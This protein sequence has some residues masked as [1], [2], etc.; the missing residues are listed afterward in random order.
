MRGFMNY[1]DITNLLNQEGLLVSC[2]NLSLSFSYLSY[3]IKDINENTLF[4]ITDEKDIQ[5]IK[6]YEDKITCYISEKEYDIKIPSIIVN[7]IISTTSIISNKFYNLEKEN[8]KLIGVI[9]ESGKTTTLELL[10]NNINYYY[11]KDYEI[12]NNSKKEIEIIELD[13]CIK[14]NKLK[15]KDILLV[16]LN[17][18][19]IDQ[20]KYKKFDTI[21][22]LNIKE[23]K[24]EKDIDKIISI[25]NNS[26]TIIMNKD[27]YYYEKINKELKENKVITYG[28]T[29]SN[30]IIKNIRNSFDKIVFTILYNNTITDYKINNKGEFNIIDSTASIICSLILGVKYISIKKSLENTTIDSNMDIIDSFKCKIIIDKVKNNYGILSLLKEV[31]NMYPDKD[32][33]L[34]IGINE[35]YSITMLKE[36]SDIISKYINYIYLTTDNPNNKEVLQTCFDFIKEFKK[37]NLPYEI[38]IDR[39]D[40]IKKC[41]DGT[42]DNEIILI[43]GKGNEKYQ[44]I[45]DEEIFYEGDKEVVLDYIKNDYRR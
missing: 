36:L 21:I 23:N 19:L 7:D 16:E 27:I 22:L 24:E 1:E 15:E 38:I 26:N 8:F 42:T 39:K 40:S 45:K 2:S 28:K 30:F 11:N 17:N 6:D 34:I 32:I 10:K 5:S 35:N 41:M 3:N 20:Y 43:L 18:N 25:L 33:K 44:L 12:F 31:K 4:I 9:G 37:Y 29:N 14:N 13:R